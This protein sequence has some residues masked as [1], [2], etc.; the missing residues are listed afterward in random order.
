MDHLDADVLAKLLTSLDFQTVCALSATCT[1]LRRAA[2]QHLASWSH[3][4]VSPL[5]LRA[6]G[7]LRVAAKRCPSLQVLVAEDTR[8]VQDTDLVPLLQRAASLRVLRLRNLRH[9]TNAAVRALVLADPPVEELRF[10]GCRQLGNEACFSLVTSARVKATLRVLSLASTSVS[11]FGVL[12][13]SRVPHLEVV[14]LSYV[15]EPDGL[16]WS[17]GTD[18]GG[19]ASH[20]RTAASVTD[21][22]VA[23]W[24]SSRRGTS[25]L[26]HLSL[27]HRKGINNE[28]MLLSNAL[29]EAGARLMFLDV[30]H[31]GILSI[32]DLLR[33]LPSLHTLRLASIAEY[34]ATDAAVIVQRCPALRSLDLSNSNELTDNDLALLAAGLPHLEEL[35]L[36]RSSRI[37]PAGLNH[38]LAGAARL[39]RLTCVRCVGEKHI[40]RL[41]RE[42]PSVDIRWD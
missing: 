40:R 26:T 17:R 15:Y 6:G 25:P 14:D 18:A 37:T 11:N 35:T 7:A 30:S 12:C 36:V 20:I 34:S 32:D 28:G 19:T 1:T 24:L 9:V 2:L 5:G 16:S 13:L 31:T 23:V 41:A 38:L 10:D 3:L 42:H 27:A 8:A 39:R 22:S 33:L 4:D 29:A 21:T